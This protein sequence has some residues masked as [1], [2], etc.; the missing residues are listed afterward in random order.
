MID[1]STHARFFAYLNKKPSRAGCVLVLTVLFTL[2]SMASQSQLALAKKLI[3]EDEGAVQTPAFQDDVPYHDDGLS[4]KR[5][6]NT[7]PKSQA[8]TTAE[9]VQTHPKKAASVTE[10]SVNPKSGNALN[11]N[12]NISD[13]DIMKLYNEI[14]NNPEAFKKIGNMDIPQFKK[15]VSEIGVSNIISQLKTK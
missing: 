4:P 2:I 7:S 9:P 11:L 14:R 13:K 1:L 5:L 6:L 8:S 15:L 3:V 10:L 12:E